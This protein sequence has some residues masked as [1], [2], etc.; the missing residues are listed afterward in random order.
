MKQ[1]NIE[2]EKIKGIDYSYK[3]SLP[4]LYAFFMQNYFIKKWS[5]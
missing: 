4:F 2:S 3:N 1:K 5:I